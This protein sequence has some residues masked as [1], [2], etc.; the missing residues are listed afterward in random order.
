MATLGLLLPLK[1]ETN[2]VLSVQSKIERLAADISTNTELAEL[3]K[4]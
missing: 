1:R 2:G 4:G 3:A